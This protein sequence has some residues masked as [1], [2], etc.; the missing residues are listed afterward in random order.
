MADAARPPWPAFLPTISSLK[1]FLYY[2]TYVQYSQAY[3]P[4]PP[5]PRCCP[6]GARMEPAV[7]TYAPRDP[8]HTVLYHVIAD[9]LETFL[10]SLDADPDAR[11]LPAYVERELYDSLQC[12]ILVHGFLR[13]GCVPTSTRCCFPSAASGGGFVRRVPVGAWSRPPRTWLSGSSA[14]CV[15]WDT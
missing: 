1:F 13:L 2:C 15:G 4:S 3:F 5:S 9:H 12:G 10:A 11:G 8:S 14:R 7:A 6:E